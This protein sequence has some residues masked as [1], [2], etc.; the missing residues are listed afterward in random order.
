MEEPQVEENEQQVYQVIDPDPT[1]DEGS[2][3]A[4]P[5]LAIVGGVVVLLAGLLFFIRKRF[6]KGQLP[7]PVQEVGCQNVQALYNFH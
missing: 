7:G 5:Q 6:Q 4:L 1:L 2:D 3:D